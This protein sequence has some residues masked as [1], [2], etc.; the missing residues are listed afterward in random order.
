[1]NPSFEDERGY[2]YIYCQ[3][4]VNFQYVDYWTLTYFNPYTSTT[5][6]Y[7]NTFDTC[8][9]PNDAW[10]EVFSGAEMGY[11]NDWSSYGLAPGCYDM[12]WK[13]LTNEY[14]DALLWSCTTNDLG[15]MSNWESLAWGQRWARDEHRQTPYAETLPTNELCS[16]HLMAT[17][18]ASLQLQKLRYRWSLPSVAGVVYRVF[19]W[20]KFIPAN[21]GSSASVVQRT[22]DVL[23]TGG[24]VYTPVFD[25]PPPSAEGCTY[26]V[27]ME[28]VPKVEITPTNRIGCPRCINNVVYSLTN[29]FVPNGVTWSIF[30]PNL[31]G[32]AAITPNGSQATV[33]PGTIGTNYTIRATSV[34]S[35]N[36]YDDATLTIY[37]PGSIVQADN[38]YDDTTIPNESHKAIRHQ[39]SPSP[40]T[41][42]AANH[43]CFVQRLTG[44]C[45]R[46][47][48]TY[49][50][51]TMYGNTVPFNYTNWVIDSFDDNAAYWSQYP[52]YN[53]DPAGGNVYFV[54]DDPGPAKAV[55]TGSVFS[56]DFTIGIYCTNEVPMSGCAAQ[57]STGTPF[58]TATWDYKVSVTTNGTF[59]HP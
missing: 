46:A 20:E 36:C 28:S 41:E 24:T 53:H 33:D 9:M 15:L 21:G 18:R 7:T 8:N 2:D 11:S 56:V 39:F 37:A 30:P 27:P 52:H 35:S 49:F 5:T 19:W 14:T 47:D 51:V 40:P 10:M 59:T 45:R 38:F 55:W 31:S 6:W 26:P 29:S 17:N 58:D 43:F 44:S 32:G 48:G 16:I 1:M 4:S 23:G 34:D 22:A 54:E 25:L 42:N 12:G 50:T 3:P 57:P 13:T